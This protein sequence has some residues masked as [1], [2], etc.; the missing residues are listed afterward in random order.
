MRS[1]AL[2]AELARLRDQADAYRTRA[3]ALNAKLM[4]LE[5]SRCEL[6]AVRE[7]LLDT[8]AAI[9]LAVH[10]LLELPHHGVLRA[11]P[12]RRRR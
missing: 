1:P 7:Q 11:R 2:A 12:S 5:A 9:D 4:T 3:I 8:S 6:H 10:H